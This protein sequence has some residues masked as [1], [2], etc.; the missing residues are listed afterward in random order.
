[1]TAISRFVVV[2]FGVRFNAACR[3]TDLVGCSVC[4]AVLPVLLLLLW[5]AGE[6]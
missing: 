2:L 5:V 4:A 6:F 1:M 3:W